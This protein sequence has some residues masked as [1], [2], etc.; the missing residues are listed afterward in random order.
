MT[1]TSRVLWWLGAPVR[2]V[3]LGLIAV[4]RVTLGRAFVGQCRFDP[5]CSA[6]AAEAIRVHGA[7]RGTGM[8]VWRVARCSP[9]TA[10]GPDPVPARRGGVG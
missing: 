1:P 8:A 2:A 6:Y 7:I 4:Y 5:T 10:G 9:L 3:L